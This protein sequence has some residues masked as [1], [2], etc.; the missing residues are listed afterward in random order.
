MVHPLP[1][2]LAI[3]C[4]FSAVHELMSDERQQEEPIN[5]P[6]DPSRWRF[7][8]AQEYPR[9]KGVYHQHLPGTLPGGLPKIRQR[10]WKTY[11]NRR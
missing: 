10:R 9:E 11:E 7:T 6:L 3:C 2:E 8:L 5:S 4:L 1:Q